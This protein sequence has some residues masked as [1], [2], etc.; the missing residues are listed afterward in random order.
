M[1]F[2]DCSTLDFD[3]AQA[4]QAEYGPPLEDAS[5]RDQGVEVLRAYANEH[6]LACRALGALLGCTYSQVARILKGEQYPNV[7]MAKRFEEATGVRAALILG[8]E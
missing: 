1:A 7:V 3:P 2:F 8:L 4:V 5:W 6:K